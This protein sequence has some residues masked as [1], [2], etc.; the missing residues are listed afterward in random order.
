[1]V[2]FVRESANKP[3][4]NG[5]HVAPEKKQIPLMNGLLVCPPPPPTTIQEII[6]FSIAPS[7]LHQ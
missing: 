6:T 7:Q 2:F 4:K 5:R 3:V 1:M